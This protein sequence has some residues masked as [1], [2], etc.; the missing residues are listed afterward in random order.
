MIAQIIEAAKSSIQ[1]LKLQVV[2]I[3][4]VQKPTS[5][6]YALQ[7]TKIVSKLSPMLGNLFEFR[8]VDELNSTNSI[9]IEGQW[10]RQDP[11]FPDACFKSEK[12]EI[13]NAGI[14]IKA[15]FPFATEITGRFKDSED[16]F[17]NDQI[18]VA[19]VAWLP[20]YVFWGKPIIIDT[21]LVSG[22]SVAQARDNHYHKPPHYI[23]FEPEDTTAR[24]GNLQQTNTNGYVF[25]DEK[26]INKKLYQ[27]AEKEIA[28]WSADELKYCTRPEYQ[29]KLKALLGKYP[30]RL[31]TN[32]AKI[33][34][35][36]HSDIEEF[37]SKI[38]ETEYKRRKIKE[39]ARLASME[40]DNPDLISAIEEL[41]LT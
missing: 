3:I 34:R 20:E 26:T 15:W 7:L 39:W 29:Q 13:N 8:I 36:Q 10:V 28:K 6:Q 14:E 40:I 38:Y 16:I 9:D 32:Y 12:L 24:T 18:Y 11:G 27:K 30:Y 25:Q 31:D 33:D 2:D 22:K 35:I 21:L 4:E 41:L 1:K 17:K 37:K 5:V 23:V 19:I